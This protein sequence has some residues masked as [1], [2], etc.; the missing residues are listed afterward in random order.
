VPVL[1]PF[2]ALVAAGLAVALVS[3]SARAAPVYLGSAARSGVSEEDRAA[4]EAALVRALR[5]Q[6]I[7]VVDAS[8]MTE[9]AAARAKSDARSALD[10]ASAAYADADWRGVLEHT[11][12]GFAAFEKGPAFSADERD[13]A[14]GRDLL[15]LRAVAA[16][17]L[18]NQKVAE[19]SARALLVI[20]PSYAPNA[21]KAPKG[22]VQLFDD[23]RDELSTFPPAP[24]D[25]RS[26]P[27]GALIVLDGKRR[28]KTPMVI[29]DVAPGIH[30]VAIE[31]RDARYTERVTLLEDGARVNAKLGGRRQASARE[32]LE[33]VQNPVGAKKLVDAASDA[34]ND[35]VVAVMLPAG[36][37]VE[38]VAGRVRDGEVQS[39]LGTRI[40]PLENDRERS[41]YVLAQAIADGTTD[42]WLDA[43]KGQDPSTLR[44]KLFTGTGSKEVEPEESVISPAVI[45]VAVV[46]G[47]V[48]LAAVGGTIGFVVLRETRKD[49]GFTWTV[50]TK[51]LE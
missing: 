7:P 46:G 47:V 39:V 44:P 51:G 4:I 41:S 37:D 30:Y 31:T 15:S 27:A 17:R 1:R 42:R 36:K 32:V 13:M 9:D 50:D 2:P 33:L 12:T 24:L 18:K 19:E 10:D 5:K 8:A 35:V 22:L 20:Q 45:A 21:K 26:K 11:A 23:V 16:L 40:G 14:L 34:G 43:A 25:V 28:G 38:V 29:P 48:A 6:G 3:S 49:Q